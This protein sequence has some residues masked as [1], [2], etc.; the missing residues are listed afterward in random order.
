MNCNEV[1][2]MLANYLGNE[3]S[4]DH[5]SAIA[6]HLQVCE[7]CAR[8]VASLQETITALAQ[9]D[10]VSRSDAM[11]RTN[12]FSVVRR[13]SATR[14]FILAS[15]RIAAV[16]ALGIVLG[17]LS[18]GST[19]ESNSTASLLPKPDEP[20]IAGASS[21][22]IHPDWMEFAEKFSR[23]SSGLTSSL[24]PLVRSYQR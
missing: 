24:R 18:N 1:S 15:L 11:D 16:L 2:P 17:R 23:N 13:N 8:E 6:S 12:G 5:R 21:D 3:L 7:S 4:N 14:H 9:L 19:S 22:S 20:V 10:T